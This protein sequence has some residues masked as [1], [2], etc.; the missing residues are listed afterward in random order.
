LVQLIDF[1]LAKPH[2][3]DAFQLSFPAKV[4]LCK[5]MNLINEDMANFLLEMN[6]TRNSLAHRLGFKFISDDAFAFVQSAARAGADFSDDTIHTDKK[7]QKNGMGL[8]P[9]SRKFFRTQRKN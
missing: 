9:S 6:P 4:D 5:A 7:M 8:M 1:K 3:F 2:Y